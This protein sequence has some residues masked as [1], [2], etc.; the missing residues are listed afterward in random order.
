VRQVE[1]LGHARWKP[2]LVI[3]ILAHWLTVPSRGPRTLSNQASREYRCDVRRPMPP[4]PLVLGFIDCINRCDL[5]GLVAMM[6][7]DHRLQIFDESPLVGREANERA[8]SGYMTSF[9]SYLIY[10]HQ[11]ADCGNG[12]VAVLGHT[13]GSHLGL[14]DTEESQE[15][16]IWVAETAAGSV[17]AWTLVEDS[18][19]NRE[20]YGL[21]AQR[22]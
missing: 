22:K 10:P 12:V 4:V 17:A 20:R 19:V 6:A 8:W 2:S 3:V 9:P 15:T 13:T 7:P 1:L 18:P 14:S 16:L 21:G 5:S 11:I